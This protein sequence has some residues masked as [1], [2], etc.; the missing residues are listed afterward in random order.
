MNDAEKIAQI[1]E[2]MPVTQHKIYLN[3]GTCGPLSKVTVETLQQGDSMELVEGRSD[4][5][6]FAALLQAKADARQAVANLV[7][8]APEEIALTHHTTEG[9]NIIAHG[10]T[11]Q[12]GDEIIT[13]KLEHEGGLIP[14]YVLRDRYGVVVHVIDVEPGDVVAQF[15]RAITPRTRLMLFSHVAWNTGLRLP[16]AEIVAMGHRHHVLSLVDGAQSFGAIPLDLPASQVDFYA[17]PGQKWLCGPEGT[18]ALYVRQD[19]MNQVA[20]TFVGF[21]S[22][23]DV[24]MY[25]FLGYFLPARTAQR[26]EVGTVY[27]PGIKAMVANLAWLRDSIGWDW[28]YS[29]IMHMAGY[30]YH[31]L[32]N[33]RGVTAITPPGP[34]AGLI[35][36]KLDGCDPAR[37][38]SQLA[39]EDI[40]LRYIRHPYALRI[41]TGFYNTEQE[42]DRL[43]ESL[44][45]ILKR[46]PEPPA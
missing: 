27:R 7:K 35:T 14:L 20:P 15:E 5:T 23:E 31:A 32:N 29:R 6:G 21:S 1:R 46:A 38:M 30:A 37:V 9:I 18:G 17:M 26:Y 28:I 43:I 2:A 3:T 10:L 25:D 36:F 19:R 39:G 42:I 45:A 4:M 40:I 22:L 44:R 33:L 24:K 34:Q 16:L 12:P 41:A 13:T 8:A 11:W